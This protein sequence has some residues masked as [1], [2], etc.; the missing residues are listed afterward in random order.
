M[1]P[2]PV[3]RPLS[4]V[5]GIVVWVRNLLFDAG[6][7]TVTDVNIPV[8]SI[9]N[10]TAGGSGKTPVTIEAVRYL[11]ESGK[12]IAVISRGY[13]R[14]TRG[15]VVVSDGK[16]ILT[17]A[18]AGGD[19][20][21]M[22][23]SHVRS[24][25]VIADEDRVRG[26]KFAVAQFGAECIVLD[27]GFQ[28]RYLKRNCDIILMDVR[29]SPFDTMLLPAG[30]RREFLGSVQ[31]AHA[32]MA[33]KAKDRTDARSLLGRKE[34]EH[35]PQIFSSTY[36]AVGVRNIFGGSS[37]SLEMLNGRTVLAVSGIANADDFHLALRMH[38]ADV[39][40]TITNGDHHRYSAS[41]IERIIDRY[42]TSN[43]DYVITTEKD[44]VKL[45]QFRKEINAIPVF[46]LSMEVKIHQHDQWMSMLTEALNGQ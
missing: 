46:F 35:V 25:V 8:I 15:T 32:V 13:G 24:A 30:Y 34:I 11:A 2:H 4:F 21:V 18:S 27:D 3:L 38:G 17:D 1:K 41:D 23:A 36:Q 7:L 42:R 29:R 6:I 37:Q 26:A 10:I 5:Y 43:I 44:A 39:A 40:S 22:I 31:R 33:T 28:H 12:K 20:P 9:G 16:K 45:E 19:E 14:S